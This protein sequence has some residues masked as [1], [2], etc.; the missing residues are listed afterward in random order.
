[1]GKIFSERWPRHRFRDAGMRRQRS[2]L[3]REDKSIARACV[4]EWF[5]AKAIPAAKK[6]AARAIVNRIGPHAIETLGQS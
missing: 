2:Q 1:M 4:E 5:L 3:G 6:L